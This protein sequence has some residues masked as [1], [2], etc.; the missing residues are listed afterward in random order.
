MTDRKGFGR[1][2]FGRAAGF[3]PLA[4]L[5]PRGA[6]AQG[7]GS[8]IP[9]GPVTVVVPYTPGS[10]PDILGRLVSAPLQQAFG[11]PVVVDNRAGAS[12]N[13]GTQFVARAA[14]DG[15]TLMMQPNTFIMNPS[16][17]R[18]VPYDPINSFVPIIQLSTGDLVVVV[19]PDVPARNAKELADLARAKPGTLDYGSP[20]VGTPQ[21]LAMALFG[22]T[23]GVTM[24][25][26]PYRGAAPS[27]QD[28]IGKRLAAMVLPV[29]TA[30]PLAQAGQIRLLAI[31]GDRRSDVAPD[32]PTLA[33]S[34]FPGSQ[35]DLWFGLFGPAGLPADFVRGVNADLNAWLAEPRTR[36]ALLAQGMKP[37]G[38]TPEALGELAKRDFARWADVIRRGGI[39]AD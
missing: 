20:G 34:G 28:L 22:L 11:Q 18:Q 27:L 17:F 2:Q 37:A 26:V 10:G 7:S 31:C 32:V 6:A 12:G 14:P 15:R 4:A 21:H 30:L 1:R 13:I 3:L 8:R 35:A 16:L 25:H 29:H 33:E 23:A 39:S 5:A 24:N 38:G 9:D 19:N 36:E